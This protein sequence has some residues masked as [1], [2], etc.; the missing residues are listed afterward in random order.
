MPLRAGCLC[1]TLF[2]VP[3]I[4]MAQSLID[5][6]LLIET[7]PATGLEAPTGLT[8]G[9][10]GEIFAIEK[11][12]GRVKLVTGGVANEVLDLDVAN[13]SERGLLGIALHP[14]FASN[15]YAYLYYSAS[16]NGSDGSSWLENRLS[17]FTWNGSA[18]VDE[19]E[20]F[21][22]PSSGSL[23]NGPNHNG[24]PILFGPDGKL[25]GA[26]GDLNRNLAEQNN[27]STPGTSAKTGGIY[28]LND[29]GTIPTDN[30]FLGEANSDFDPW[31][32]Y[33]VRN[34]F[35][36]AFDPVTGQLWDT[37]NGPN[38]FDEINVVASG[39][40]SG[41]NEI[42]GPADPG[43]LANLV[44]LDGSAYSDPEFSF[45]SPIGITSLEFLADSTLA[46]YLN[47]VLVG[48]VNTQSLYYL[49]LNASR[50]GFELTGGLADLVAD[51]AAE[52]NELLFGE[53]F[54]IVTDLQVG[55]DGAL[56]VVSLTNSAIYRIAPVP[57]MST[58]LL[59]SAGMA[60]MVL[61]IRRRRSHA[62]PS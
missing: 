4:S 62:N 39:F 50:D 22:I 23:P 46:D 48:D 11:N 56:Y 13:N 41:W 10:N 5:S 42:M 51:S 57:E 14:D 9:P 37:E 16:G 58:V 38:V 54:G 49:P 2:C 15:N 3:V 35:G 21:A 26:T 53:D 61:V 6:N 44:E 8:F 20:L 36:L 17:R 1:A 34:S 33:G 24:G 25:Y 47:G 32:A 55:P 52:R 28:R 60:G 59:T 29:D 31:Y 45:A 12:T 18:L 40:N 7:V 19:E 30:P 43:D 27:T